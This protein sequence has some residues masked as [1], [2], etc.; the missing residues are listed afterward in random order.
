MH[1]APDTE[2]TLLFTVAL[3]NTDPGASKSGLDE[4][5]STAQLTALLDAHSYSGHFDRDAA[6]L[7]SVV[8]TRTLLRTVWSLPRD[9]AVADV[10]R[11]LRDAGALPF[12][13]RHEPFDWHLHATESDA[14]LAERIRVEVSL[15]IVDVIRSGETG[16]MRVCEARDCEGLLLDLSRNGSKRFCSV[17]CGNRMNQLAFRERL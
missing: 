8:E 12:L 10:N 13:V 7:A 1:F 14:P 9:D 16:R 17:R 4:I 11:M 2:D 3:A 5:S 15:A 6:E